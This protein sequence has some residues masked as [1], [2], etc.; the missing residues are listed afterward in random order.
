MD[1]ADVILVPATKDKELALVHDSRT[2]SPPRAGHVLCHA[3]L[4]TRNRV[5][6]GVSDKLSHL[7]NIE[8]VQVDVLRVAAAESDNLRSVDGVGCVEPLS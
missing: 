2:M 3:D 5:E 1:V 4:D 6:F 7:E 8:V